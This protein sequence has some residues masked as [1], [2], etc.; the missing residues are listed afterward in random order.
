MPSKRDPKTKDL[1][2]YAHDN[3]AS[4]VYM[5]TNIINSKRYIGLTRVG[6][7]KRMATH[8]Y[9]ARADQPGH[10]QYLY[11][12]IRKYGESAFRSEEL[13]SHETYKEA[14]AA[15]REAIARF[16]PEYNLTRGGEGIVGHRHNK[17]T[18]RK[19]SA[20]AK[21]RGAPWAKGKCPPEVREKLAASAR[22]R[23][24]TF[25]PEQRARMSAKRRGRRNH[26][27]S[28]PVYCI[29]DGLAF[30]NTSDA[31]THYGLK[32]GQS[33]SNYCLRVNRHQDGK[34]FV[35]VDDWMKD[36]IW[37]PAASQHTTP[38]QQD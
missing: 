16:A 27:Q 7:A 15:E 35:Y 29:T 23:K 18:R 34:E 20:K 14:C 36:D 8:F 1:F 6:L 32:C 22:R 37:P 12:A 24:G 31:A 25:T 11:A 26:I 2:A 3:R 9:K 19:M 5:I 38:Q 30:R 17:E 33:I 13:S 28:R 4:I 21:A 10:R